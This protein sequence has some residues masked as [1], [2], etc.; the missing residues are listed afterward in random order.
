MIRRSPQ[1]LFAPIAVALAGFLATACNEAKSPTEPVAFVAKTPT[2]APTVV[3]GEPAIMAGIV[4]AYAG[5]P[6]VAGA[7]VECQGKS[8]T[9]ASDGSYLLGG[10]VS[11]TWTVTVRYGGDS[12]QDQSVVLRPGTNTVNIGLI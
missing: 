9:T 1:P 7:I 11:G 5:T 8:T 10:L 2:P 6:P 12:S 3:A 4:S